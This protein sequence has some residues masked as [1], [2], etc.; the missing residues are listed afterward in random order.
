M[1]YLQLNLHEGTKV[2]FVENSANMSGGAIYVEDLSSGN[3][4]RLLSLFNTLCFLQ[5]EVDLDESKH[6]TPDKWRV[7][8]YGIQFLMYNTHH[9]TYYCIC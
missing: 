5:F 2:N 4:I 3:D 6:L 8:S 1:L 9:K 7:S